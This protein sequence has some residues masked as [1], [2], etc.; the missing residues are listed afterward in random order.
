MK[1][2]RWKW[3]G[4]LDGIQG[5]LRLFRVMWETGEPGDGRG[6]HSNML[7]VGLQCRLFCHE[8]QNAQRLIVF[9][10]L[11]IHRKRSF[12]GTFG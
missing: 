3:V 2:L 1:N 6:G 5:H 4:R 12:G 10:G 11:R 7:S 8:R 9:A